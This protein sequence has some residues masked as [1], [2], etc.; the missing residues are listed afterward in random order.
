V[1]N[2]THTIFGRFENVQKDE[3]F[4]EGEPLAGQV[5]RVNKLSLGY[6]YDFPVWHGLQFGVG[7]LGSIHFIPRMNWKTCTARTRRRT[8][9]SGA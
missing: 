6:I 5:F 9:C 4:N 3:L 8:C 7:A 2:H 1:F